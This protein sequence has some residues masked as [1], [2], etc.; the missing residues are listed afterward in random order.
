MT[1]NSTNFFN[2]KKLSMMCGVI[3]TLAACQQ[4]SDKSTAVTQ[5]SSTPASTTTLALTV[6]ANGKTSLSPVKQTPSIHS[7]V[8]AASALNQ[9]LATTLNN[10]FILAINQHPKLSD[11]QKK[12]LSDFD[13]TQT[14]GLAQELLS[15]HLTETELK[16]A[17]D[18]YQLP[19]GQKIIESNHRFSEDLKQGKTRPT[20]LDVTD[21]E[22]LQISAFVQTATG[23][24]IQ[25]LVTNQLK[26]TFAPIES[27]QLQKCQISASTFN[28]IPTQAK[29][30]V[31][32]STPKP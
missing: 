21:D 25:N 5:P 2:L 12:C 17:N 4:Q 19:V 14:V 30:E 11:E 15:N 13:T 29:A 10:G 16:E 28:A 26:A 9:L 7:S 6:D 18:F 3:L 23:Q 8:D 32:S 1:T 20:Q 22:K 24:K 27:A 31:T